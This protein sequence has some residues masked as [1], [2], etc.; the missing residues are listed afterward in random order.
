METAATPTPTAVGRLPDLVNNLLIVILTTCLMVGFASVLYMLQPSPSALMLPLLGMAVAIEGLLTTRWLNHPDRREVHR[1][2][3]RLSEWLVILLCLRLLSWAVG[4]GLPNWPQIRGYL[5]APLSFLDLRFVAFVFFSLIAWERAVTFGS[6]LQKL[7]LSESELSFHTLPYNE[8]QQQYEDR[9]L[10]SERRSRYGSLINNWLFGGFAL[11]LCAAITTFQL[12]AADA[13]GLVQLRNISRLG[14]R[15]EILVSLLLYFLLGLWFISRARLVAMHARWITNGIQV[16][17]NMERTWHRAGIGLLV[18]V[19]FVA[20]L[21][22]IGST[23]GI[24]TILAAIA[25]F[26]LTV[27]TLLLV[28]LSLFI[29]ALLSLIGTSNTEYDLNLKLEEVLPQT[30]DP[31]GPANETLTLVAGTLFW[32]LIIGITVAAVLFFLRGRGYS[33]GDGRLGLLWQR[34]AA[35]WRSLWRGASGRVATLAKAIRQRGNAPAGDEATAPPWRFIRLNA[36][37]AREQI[38][39]F[40][41]S[42]VRRATEQGVERR[43]S[44]TPTEY[45][46]DLKASWPEAETEIEALTAAFLAARYSPQPIDESDLS[47]VKRTWKRVKASLRRRR[48]RWANQTTPEEPAGDTPTP[49]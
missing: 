24:A 46:A 37:S 27:T 20:A 47:P 39:Y 43:H 25:S 41:L 14:L 28:L 40:Y 7:A 49:E 29:Y 26:L 6:I 35:W 16:Q 34:F 32:L 12:P 22:P 11:T 45:A 48:Q 33:L 4:G 30:A 38:R 9:P 10:D 21:L 13:E 2:M 18:V 19:G 44:E 17:Q 8:R 36:L 3:Y 23:F 31:A 1:I 15:P 42:T 5:Q